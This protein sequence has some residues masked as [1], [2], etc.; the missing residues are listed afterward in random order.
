MVEEG[1]RH[2]PPIFFH[3]KASTVAGCERLSNLFGGAEFD[4]MRGRFPQQRVQQLFDE[5]AR[6]DKKTFVKWLVLLQPERKEWTKRQQ[7][8]WFEADGQPIR[9]ILAQLL[10]AMVR[11]AD[12]G[13]LT[14]T[15]AARRRAVCAHL[16]LDRIL[17]APELCA[18]EKRA[19]MKACLET[20]FADPQYR[21]LLLSTGDAPLHERPMRGRGNDWTS[22]GNDWLGRLLMELR[23]ELRRGRLP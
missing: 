22:P 13:R 7:T 16:G 5:L 12:D 18:E 15:A 3:S 23:S 6:C 21:A 20:K 14:R 10:G 2:H 8:F 1:R 17:V 19:R 4:Y 9:G 11:R